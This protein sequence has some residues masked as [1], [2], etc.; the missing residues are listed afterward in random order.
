MIPGE[1]QV[2]FEI[3]AVRARFHS[4][5]IGFHKTAEMEIRIHRH[6]EFR[7]AFAVFNGSKIGSGKDCT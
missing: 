7:L 6:G 4:A 3:R 2:D 1:R 5:G